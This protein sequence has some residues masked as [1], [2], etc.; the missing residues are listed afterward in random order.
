[1]EKNN[2]NEYTIITALKELVESL[3][4]NVQNISTLDKEI[5]TK[6]VSAVTGV[7]MQVTSVQND[8]I[9]VNEPEYMHVDI[10]EIRARRS[11]E[12]VQIEKIVKKLE[13]LDAIRYYG[14]SDSGLAQL[15]SDLYPIHRYNS[16][17]KMFYLYDGTRWI[18]DH[19]G[20]SAKHDLKLLCKALLQYAEEISADNYTKA[21]SKLGGST[22][23]NNV[24]IDI[25]D[26]SAFTTGDLDKNDYLLNV[27]NGTLDLSGDRPILLSH[28][29]DMLLSKI[30]RVKYNPNAAGEEWKKFVDDIMLGEKE[31]IRY[32]QK[33]A[34][35][36]LTG[37]TQEEKMFIL[38]G[39]TTRNGKSTYCETLAYLEGEYAANVRPESL[40]QKNNVDSRQASGDIARLAGIRYCSVAEPRKRM[41]LDAGIVKN[42]TGRDGITARHLHEREFTFWPKMTMIMNTNHL[43]IIS[44]DTLFS[45]GRVVVVEFLRHFEET[46]QDRTLKDR[47]SS[48]DSLSGILNWCL[49][50]WCA[51]QKEGLEPPQSILDATAQ[52]RMDSDKIG[53]F[54]SE[55]LLP[56]D[57]INT[58][59][60]DAYMAYT[61]WCQD[62]GYGVENK[63]NFFA[64]L[65]NKGIFRASGTVEGKTVRNVIT[66]YI[67]RQEWVATE[68]VPSLSATGQRRTIPNSAPWVHPTVTPFDK[69]ASETNKQM[70]LSI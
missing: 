66:G 58:T 36:A 68:I 35:L 56:N 32:L 41:V 64:E 30:C 29:P 17:A 23:R 7:S 45:S 34:G 39:P 25:K 63:S 62:A 5:L 42:L 19:E 4:N 14:S 54:I 60:K 52:Y 50:G 6:V 37:N 38:Y 65:K 31:K 61:R 67:I 13:S 40:S 16:T 18:P 26:N 28:H 55:C 44:D 11:A 27:E 43:P 46:E 1:M 57:S 47:L 69:N 33:I 24:L 8:D 12:L 9:D 3:D 2:A 51:Y 22:K 59:G 20:L 21:I 15:Y 70:K 10:G 49:E 53:A 48:P